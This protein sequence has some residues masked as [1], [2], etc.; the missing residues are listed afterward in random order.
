M[1]GTGV[2]SFPFIF[3]VHSVVHQTIFLIEDGIRCIVTHKAPPHLL[4]VFQVALDKGRRDSTRAGS[5]ST[6]DKNYDANNTNEDIK[7]WAAVVAK[8]VAQSLQTPEIRGSNSDT[9]D[10]RF[11]FS[12]QQILF[13]TKCIEKAKIKKK[14]QTMAHF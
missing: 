2:I 6:N 11:E 4:K 5:R 9:R 13:T 12:H 3:F 8:L 10:P 7:V 14:R 1:L